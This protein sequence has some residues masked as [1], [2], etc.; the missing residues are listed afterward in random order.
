MKNTLMLLAL[1]LSMAVAGNAQSTYPVQDTV[2]AVAP[3]IPSMTRYS[4]S[5][6]CWHG[7]T[8]NYTTGCRD[9]VMAWIL[10]Y[11]WEATGFQTSIGVYLSANNVSTLSSGEA[12]VYRDLKAAH[13]MV[14]DR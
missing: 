2:A 5:G 3:H 4:G 6:T 8:Y 13:M 1:F 11:P 9:S 14:I 10:A 7:I 12:E